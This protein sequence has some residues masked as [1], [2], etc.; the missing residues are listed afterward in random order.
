MWNARRLCRLMK[1]RCRWWQNGLAASPSKHL[2]RSSR[3]LLVSGCTT[4]SEQAVNHAPIAPHVPTMNYSIVWHDSP[5]VDL[6]TPLGGFIRATAGSYLRGLDFSDIEYSF[7]GL[8]QAAADSS[9][10]IA[11]DTL[12]GQDWRE[13]QESSWSGAKDLR[14]DSVSERD[15]R[16]TA[17]VCAF[18]DRLL[19]ES[20]ENPNEYLIGASS[21]GALRVIEIAFTRTGTQPKLVDPGP[22][23]RPITP[24]VFGQWPINSIDYDMRYHSPEAARLEAR[25]S[26]E[27]NRGDIPRVPDEGKTV[28]KNDPSASIT[29]SP[30]WSNKPGV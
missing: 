4:D 30:G 13:D 14:V 20:S 6:K 22:S 5:V 17:I 25:E 24:D 7:P 11:E 15:G 27:A 9:P 23:A 18:P 26:C 1:G 19:R 21:E 12:N 29:P 10:S 3:V 28:P 16:A 8:E 2:L